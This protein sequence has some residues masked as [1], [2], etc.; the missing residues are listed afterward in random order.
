MTRQQDPGARRIHADR[1]CLGCGN[2]FAPTRRGQ[3]Y[4]R[5]SC[6]DLAEQ[7]RHGRRLPLEDT[8][9]KELERGRHD[10]AIGE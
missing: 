7:R 10:H 5:P 3:R 8:E 9:T 2:A 1:L 4:C 6:R